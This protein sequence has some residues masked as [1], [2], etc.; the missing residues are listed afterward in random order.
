[1]IGLGADFARRGRLRAM[2]PQRWEYMTARL[3][4]SASSKQEKQLAEL[5]QL[6]DQGWKVVAVFAVS[7]GGGELLLARPK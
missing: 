7:T 2:T 6:G 4:Y 1:M 3:P 5:N